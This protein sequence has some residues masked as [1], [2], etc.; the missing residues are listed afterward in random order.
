M[1]DKGTVTI[2]RIEDGVVIGE[3]RPVGDMTARKLAKELCLQRD[4]LTK[5]HQYIFNEAKEKK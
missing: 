2:K 4:T 5:F 3:V 1:S